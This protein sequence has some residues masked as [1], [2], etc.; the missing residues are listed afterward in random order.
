MG[1]SPRWQSRRSALRATRS[2]RRRRSMARRS[3]ASW[4]RS[5]RAWRRGRGGDGFDQIEVIAQGS[6]KPARRTRRGRGRARGATVQI[7]Q[8]SVRVG[9]CEE[10]LGRRSRRAGRRADAGAA[11]RAL[12]TPAPGGHHQVLHADRGRRSR[13]PTRPLIP[14]S[15]TFSANPQHSQG[16]PGIL[17]GPNT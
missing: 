17:A 8:G 1:R 3:R 11:V 7:V 2:T 5:A 9:R 10:E 12:R 6:R 4:N 14:L 16:D 15:S 13:L